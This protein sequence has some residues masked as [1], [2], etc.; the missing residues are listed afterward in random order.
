MALD[1]VRFW[2]ASI[3]GCDV[4]SWMMALS[5]GSVLVGCRVSPAP[6]APVTLRPLHQLAPAIATVENATTDGD[7]ITYSAS[8][9]NL[10]SFAR[11]MAEYTRVSVVVATQ[12][13]E[14][15]VTMEV[16]D[17][18]LER[19][20]NVAARQAGTQVS[21]SGDLYF[22]G[23]PRTEDRG[24]LVRRV[25]QLSV[26]DLSGFVNNMVTDVGTVTVGEGGIM[27]VSDRVEALSKIDQA[28]TDLLE[29]SRDRWLVEL[30]V[31]GVELG[32]LDNLG[33]DATLAGFVDAGIPEGVS[34]GLNLSAV[35]EVVQ[36]SD[37]GEVLARPLYLV[38]AGETVEF[39]RGTSVPIRSAIATEL[40]TVETVEFVDV[41]LNVSVTLNSLGGDE[42][43]CDLSIEDDRILRFDG[44]EPIISGSTFAT[45]VDVESGGEYLVG[46]L[47]SDEVRTQNW[48]RAGFGRR[49]T[50]STST[51][52][53]WLRVYRVNGSTRGFVGDDVVESAR[54]AGAA[55][56]F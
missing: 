10:G 18:P 26:E 3:F 32:A 15:V 56:A 53:I 49:S 23:E 22:I 43:V 25:G 44:G 47:Q 13:Q 39:T 8:G 12:F 50:T 7:L 46:S 27:V 45:T 4:R 34:G 37:V 55:R 40:T 52:Q 36:S 16:R 30:H 5:C 19:V 28:L 21:R 2:W 41:G 51:T 1:P 14:A 17:Q 29:I 35:L 20:L 24:T 54:K 11:A 48:V 31:I 6:A 9:I 42:A 38:N 33:V